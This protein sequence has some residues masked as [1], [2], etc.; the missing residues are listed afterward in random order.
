MERMIL[1]IDLSLLESR[2]S[3]IFCRGLLSTSLIPG[4]FR[5]DSKNYCICLPKTIYSNGGGKAYERKSGASVEACRESIQHKNDAKK[6]GFVE[7]L[8]KFKF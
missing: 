7:P 6:K 8:L 1:Q 4:R 5:I 2:V 3:N